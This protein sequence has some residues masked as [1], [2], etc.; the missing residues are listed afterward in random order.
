MNCIA[1]VALLLTCAFTAAAEEA[2]IA[3][4]ATVTATPQPASEDLSAVVDR[5]THTAIVF[6]VGTEGEG[7]ITFT[8]DEPRQVSGVRLYQSHQVYY[9][10]AYLIEADPDGDGT[11]DKLLAEAAEF[12]LSEWAAHHWEPLVLK[13]VR[14]RSVA[15]VSKGKRAHPALAEFEIIGPPR[16]GDLQQANAAGI[17]VAKLPAVRPLE[18]TTALV[19][20]GR[21]P[22]VIAPRDQEYQAATQALLDGLAAAG[23]KAEAATDIEAAD[24]ANRTVICLGNMLNNPLIERLYWNRYTFA[25]ALVPGPGQYLLH[26][27]YDPYPYNGGNNVIIIG[28]SDPAGADSGVPRFLEAL[29][30]GKLGYLVQVGPKVVL[31]PDAA[32]RIASQQPDPTFT[33]LTANANKYLQTGCEEYANQAIVVMQIMA[34]MYA[35]GGEREAFVGSSSHRKMPWPE[36]TSSWEILCAWDAFEECPLIGDELRLDFTNA[37]LTF[38]RDLKDHVSGYA[39]IGRHDLVSWNHTTFPLLGL[40]FGARY[41]HRYYGLADMPEKLAKAKACFLAQAKSWKPQ[42]DADS[43][44]TLTTEHSQIYCLAENEMNY[45]TSGNMQKYADYIVG[46]CDD[47]GLAGGFGD[48]G[49]SSSPRLPLK[50]LP[51][52]LWWT[53]D[54]GYKWLLQ[55]Y[56]GGTWQNPYER[57]IEPVQPSR[58]DGVKVF[59]TDPQVYE[60]IQTYPTYNEPFAKSDVPL[61]EAFDKISFR[62]GGHY[63]LLDGISRGKHLHYDGNSITE[64]VEAGERWLLDH[65]Y[66]TRNTTEH[67]MLSILRNG[68]CD[69]LVP[70]LSGLTEYGDVAL[71][72]YTNTYTRAY[73]GCDW[74]RRILWHRDEWFLVADTVVPREAGYYDFDLTWK[75]IDEAGNQRV[76]N[77]KDFVAERGA[78]A[79]TSGC[80]LVDDETASGGKALLM[81]SS[82]SRI[83]CGVDLPAGEYSLA[84]IGYGADT[85]SD[86]LWVAV[87]L[88]DKQSFHLNKGRYGRSAADHALTSDTP[89][90]TLDGEGPHL[91]LV[92]LRERPPVR[93]DRF[94]FQRD[95]GQAHVYE[96]ESLPP[97]P[98]VS[99]DLTRALYIKPATPLDAA[100]V[101]NHEH[102]G[103]TLPVSILHQRK[104]GQRQAGEPVTFT[105]LMYVSS[106]THRRDLT[107]VQIAPNLL[108]VKGSDPALALLGEVDSPAVSAQ[109]QA[110][111]LGPEYM[112][113]SRLR[114]L[115]LPGI[116]LSS[117]AP[118]DIVGDPSG[119]GA[120]NVTAPAGGAKLEVEIAGQSQSV[121]LHA[122]KNPLGGAEFP[123]GNLLAPLIRQLI[124]DAQPAAEAGA[125]AARR[126][127]TEPLWSAFAAD[128]QVWRIKTADL[129]DGKGQ[130]LFVC[131]GP[132]LHCL[133]PA[134]KLLWSFPAKSL[135]RDVAF[136]D[137]RD[138]PG[139]E[140]V[141]GSADT[142]IYILSAAGELLDQHEMRGMPWARSFGD[143]AYAIFNLL[144]GDLTAD[145]KPDFLVSM[146]N[147]DLQALSADWELLWKHDY[148]LHGSMAMS[149]EDTDGD[150]Q[151]DTIFVADKYGSSHGCAFDGKIKYRRYTSIGD[152]CYVVADLNGDGEVEVVTGSSTGDL[153]A[154]PFADT[155]N[156]LWRF[157]NFGYPVNR[158]VAGD[159]NGDGSDEVVLAS[160]TGY[161]YVLDG[162]GGVLWQNRAGSCVNDAIV[163]EQPGRS[164]VAYCDESGL[165]RISDGG[166][167]LLSELRTPAPPR[168]LTAL[169]EAGAATLIIALADGRV[170]SYALP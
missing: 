66:L 71:L 127:S 135:V 31:T 91:L 115:N 42:E 85:S 44:L 101:T 113:V 139:D 32:R 24:P 9:S 155:S 21:P 35:P 138:N 81:D 3:Y 27:I 158:L 122:G 29:Q 67:T 151:P 97:P 77:G 104:S 78:A 147:F 154:T 4:L 144:V 123:G 153:I 160:G 22:A 117:T 87:D 43:Y 74:Q 25:D 2:N 53:G 39:G 28:C 150:G 38:T 102:A 45:F 50:A 6:E 149:S 162:S 93:I 70:S 132:V 120:F 146:A 106:P 83:A 94:I 40:H 63:L 165:V 64:F 41:F 75:T 124:D 60:W 118:I 72:G 62:G 59:M 145:G 86:S 148:A 58:F 23:V 47:Q 114:T 166:G 96:A 30:D 90:V 7:A 169:G 14:F 142:Y 46:I 65:D 168:L 56:T 126:E 20:N 133:D 167:T 82:T 57:G 116:K 16:P 107:P 52:A 18:R 55:R 161:L 84:V 99:D 112:F 108:A 159:L 137:V 157:D 156:T 105:S 128:S 89:K 130:R 134:G 54:G 1:G 98:Q 119:P 129:R 111:L 33:E 109:L 80:L 95:G 73:N 92:T 26:T 12:P 131:R 141:V 140:V 103:I 48:S 51:L 19:V 170:M 69:E 61:E 79:E 76:V 88:G 5:N 152:V 49:V 37:L 136:G 34:E 8:F 13:A 143:A 10:T 11:F 163:I 15:G 110:A 17:T 125:A 68:R 100:W 36:E 121:T 164:L